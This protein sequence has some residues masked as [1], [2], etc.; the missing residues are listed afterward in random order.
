M[1]FVAEY[2]LKFAEKNTHIAFEAEDWEMAWI[3][4]EGFE[5]DYRIL[6]NVVEV[7]E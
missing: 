5:K 3:Q 7:K 2:Y 6:M 1:N 4:A